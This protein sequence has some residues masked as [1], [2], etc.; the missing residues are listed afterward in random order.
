[1]ALTIEQVLEL[2]KKKQGD[3]TQLDFAKKLGVTR[4]YLIDVYMKR[5]P[6]GPSI[7]EF[8]KLKKVVTVEY[9]KSS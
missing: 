5:R 9:E 7:L 8:L 6:P 4:G 2:L 3:T 1:M